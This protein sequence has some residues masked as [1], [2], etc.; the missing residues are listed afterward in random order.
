MNEWKSKMR[1]LEI[2]FALSIR[3][4][5]AQNACS[6]DV[7]TK[8]VEVRQ[9]YRNGTQINLSIVGCTRS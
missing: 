1:W 7:V 9:S 5:A 2:D 8:R 4:H 3:M 6:I